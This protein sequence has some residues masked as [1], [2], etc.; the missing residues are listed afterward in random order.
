M[1]ST[2]KPDCNNKYDAKKP[3]ITE[4]PITRVNWYKHVDWL[5][6]TFIVSIP[7]YGLIQAYWTPLQWQT[8]IWAIA[9]YFMTG[10][11]ITAGYHR[12]WAH[13]SYT[14][15]TPLKVFL[16]AVGGG[17]SPGLHQM[18]GQTSPRSS[19]LHRHRR[20]IHT[21]FTRGFLYCF[22]QLQ[23]KLDKKRQTLDWGIPLEQLPLVDWDGYQK[24]VK[25]GRALIVIA[26]VVHDVGDFIKDH[27]GEKGVNLVRHRQGRDGCF[28]WRSLQP[29]QRRA[30]SSLHYARWRSSWRL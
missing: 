22:Q 4:E 6:A 16:T 21:P 18:V 23:K 28:Q 15:S 20:K 30:Q 14:A 19:P 26:G 2:L 17:R 13:T 1:A 9:Y 7:L 5:N 25:S 24:K 27:P 11:G 8:A 29:L 10:L 12:L 3:H